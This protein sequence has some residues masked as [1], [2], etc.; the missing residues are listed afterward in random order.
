MPNRI[1]VTGVAGFIG[2]RFAE[3]AIQQGWEVV[4]F[5]RNSDQKSFVRIKH[6]MNNENFHL[7]LGDLTDGNA[8]SGLVENIDVVVNFAAK[9]FVDHSI[10]DPKPFINSNLLGTYNLLEQARMYKTKLFF[11]VS[12]D[13]VYGAILE[14]SYKEDARLNPTNPYSA[15]KAAADVLAISYYNTY[16]LPVIISRTE[17]NYGPRQHPQKAIPV[18]VKKALAGESLPIY[19]D[20]KHRR[21]WLHVQDHCEAIMHLINRYMETGDGAGE[22][23]HVAGEQEL[24]NIE[25]AK[26]IFEILEVEG[27]MEF[28]DDWDIRPGHDRRYALDTSKLRDTGWTARYSLDEGLTETVIWYKNNPWWFK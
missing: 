17:N 6:L 21:M 22:I 18:F 11:Q 19:G 26:K 12:T 10:R 5:A 1:L 4:G 27:K 25:L 16:K 20:G 28:I 9:T 7:V 23:Y 24:E 15:T 13:E 14:G 2:S 8:V 3:L